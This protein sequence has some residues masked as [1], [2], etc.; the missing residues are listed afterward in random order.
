LI[1]VGIR[2]CSPGTPALPRTSFAFAKRADLLVHEVYYVD[3]ATLRTS[4]E[5]RII[6][7]H[8][9]TP[10]Q[11]GEIFSRVQPRLALHSHIG[12]RDVDSA[13]PRRE[14]RRIVGWKAA[15]PR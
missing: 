9:T 13:K 8:H 15:K 3:E 6:V 1:T 7:R 12:R 14:G 10:E 4:P 11:A 2:S 5:E